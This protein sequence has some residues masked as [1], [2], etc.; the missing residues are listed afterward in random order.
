VR[1]AYAGIG[2]IRAR[3]RRIRSDFDAATGRLKV[4]IQVREGPAVTVDSIALPEATANADDLDLKLKTGQPFDLAAYAS[5][6][7]TLSAWLRSHG[8]IDAQ[9][10]ATLETKG[11][12]VAVRYLLDDAVRPRVGEIK[13]RTS[14]KTKA[15]LIRH[16]ITLREGELLEPDQLAQSRERLTELGLFRSVEVRLEPRVGDA[17]V[18]DV[19]V[20]LV[21]RPD[22][23]V[24]YGLRYTTQ[25]EGGGAG[26]APSAP[27]GG[28]LQIGGGI[29]FSNPLGLGVKT[30]AYGIA[31]TDR[32]SWGVNLDSATLA[33]LR[34]RTQLF[35]FKDADDT[36][37]NSAFPSRVNGITLQQSAVAL[38][39]RR[40]GRSRDR[41]RLQWGYTFKDIEY[42]DTTQERNLLQGN[43]GFVSL[44]AIGDERDSLTDPHR[45]IFWTATSELAR[46]SLGSD[47]DYMRLYGQFFAYIPLGPLVWAQG[48][49]AG[50]VP[51][52][53]PLLLIED[54]FRAG[55]A[56][57]VRG[58]QQ[59]GLGVQDDAGDSLGGQAVAIFNQE[60]RFP[61]WK[62]LHGGV[63]WDA[64]N[65]WLLSRLF[66]L[67]DLRQSVGAGLRYMFPFGPIRVEYAWILGRKPDEPKGRFVFGLGHA[68]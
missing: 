64:G 20:G 19:T 4:N 2:H 13:I 38:R 1:I 54:R 25:G 17:Q 44:S 29:E 7:D 31:A 55:G 5:D 32:Q 18:R 9:V 46:T 36:T 16:A 24:T 14:G 15:G 10:R 8:W 67:K 21:E 3:V 63:F 49:R 57:T 33:G 35:V 50:T 41:L 58:F 22:V 52:T 34:L 42:L 40:H 66:D 26:G 30:R 65:V 47:V 43:R 6:R 23:E 27:Q 60:L 39:D 68:F 12:T 61:I 48:Y 37:T 45:G 28:R 59:N 53:D 56:S 11:Q 51:G 62:S